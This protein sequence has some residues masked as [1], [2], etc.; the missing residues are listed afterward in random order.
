VRIEVVAEDITNGYLKITS[1][2]NPTFPKEVAHPRYPLFYLAKKGWAPGQPLER[3][4][5]NVDTKW[6]VRGTKMPIGGAMYVVRCPIHPPAGEAA[7]SDVAG[8]LYRRTGSVFGCHGHIWAV[9]GLNVISAFVE[10]YD[11]ELVYDIDKIYIKVQQ[12]LEA[13]MGEDK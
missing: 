7:S 10:M 2:S 12:I 4:D 13:I 3:P 5:P 9:R 11:E 6:A 8:W 1:Q